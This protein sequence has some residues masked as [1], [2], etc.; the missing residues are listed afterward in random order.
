LPRVRFLTG[1][2]LII[3]LAMATVGIQAYVRA[4][5]QQ[6]RITALQADL[7]GLQGRIAADERSAARERRHVR[8]VAAQARNARRALSRVRWALQSV[9]SESQVAGVRNALAAYGS[10]IPQLQSEIAGLNISWKIN[11]AKPATDA[12]R[13]STTAPISASCRSALTRR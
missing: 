3:A 13:L 6:A 2:A 5:H 12:F 11:P 7:A 8:S 4:G 9:P 1:L 10:C